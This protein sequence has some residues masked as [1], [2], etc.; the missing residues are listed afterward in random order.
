MHIDARTDTRTYTDRH[1]RT[2]APIHTPTHPHRGLHPVRE[3]GGRAVG[4]RAKPAPLLRPLWTFRGPAKQAREAL[5]SRRHWLMNDISHSASRR[6]K[7]VNPLPVSPLR[8]RPAVLCSDEGRC[9]RAA[10]SRRY[11]PPPCNAVKRTP[12]DPRK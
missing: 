10:K 12:S 11:P 4:D 7:L 9:S 8:T 2:N 3:M 5:L 1:A 6:A